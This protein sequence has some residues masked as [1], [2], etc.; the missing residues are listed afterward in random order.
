MPIVLNG[1]TGL[2][3]PGIDVAAGNADLT[4]LSVAG[5]EPLTDEQGEQL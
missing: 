3:S 1:T 5:N 4:T 2:T